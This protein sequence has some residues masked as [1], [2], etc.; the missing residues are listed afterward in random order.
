MEIG[1]YYDTQSLSWT[2]GGLSYH[3]LPLRSL[4]GCGGF[5]W[6]MLWQSTFLTG[7]LWDMTI[8]KI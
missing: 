8:G 2:D 1:S 7:R 3:S 6:Q 5:A 4:T